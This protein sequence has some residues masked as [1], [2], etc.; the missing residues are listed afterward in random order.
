MANE[1]RHLY[2]PSTI[3]VRG[4]EV[5]V[6]P[7]LAVGYVMGVGDEVP[8]ALEQIGVKVVM[9]GENDL[10]KGDL[11]QFDAIVIGIRATAVRD[12]LEAYSNRIPSSTG[13]TRSPG[14]TSKAG[15]KS[16]GRSG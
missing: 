5:K 4:I 11:D 9:L 6:A 10:A 14:P 2:R 1:P 3:D 16:A 7:N 15:S 12:D 8:K 13:R